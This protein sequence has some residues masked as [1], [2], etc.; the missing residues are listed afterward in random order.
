MLNLGFDAK[1]LFNNFTGLGNY[2]RTLVRSLAEF[3]PEHAYFLFTPKVKKVKETQFYLQNPQFNLVEP[4]QKWLGTWWRT[5][6]MK[7]DLLNKKIDLYHGL[8][9]EIPIGLEKTGIKSVVTI[10]DVIFKYYPKHYRP[11]DRQIYDRKFSSACRRANCIITI[12]ESSKR[13]I[14]KFYKTPAEKVVVIYPSCDDRFKLKLGKERIKSVLNQHNLPDNFLLYVGSIIERKN[15]LGVVKAMRAL[16]K[17]ERLPLVVI[18]KG[19]GYKEKV[20]Q[21]IQQNHLTEEVIFPTF[22]N[23]DDLPAIYQ[24]ASIL[25]FPSIY[26]GFGL[27]IIEALWSSTP[28]ITSNLSSLPE[29]AGKG[30]LLIDPHEPSEIASAI[31][32]ILS[33]TE[34]SQQLIREG[35]EQVKKFEAATIA[36]SIMNTYRDILII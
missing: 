31:K 28:V 2:S 30:A 17:S 9:H 20:M 1:R 29:A 23:N 13:D 6:S 7:K 34:L 11:I 14:I 36:Q 18:G 26:E 12:S 5:S 32:R 16:K 25:I 21:F 27:P 35:L 10:H 33:D 24:A 19:S 4:P 22:V 8:S 3:Y 15:L